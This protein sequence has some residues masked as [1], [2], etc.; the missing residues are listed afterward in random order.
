VCCGVVVQL[1][2]YLLFVN[3]RLTKKYM[4]TNKAVLGMF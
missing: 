2:C 3:D 4:R 1:I